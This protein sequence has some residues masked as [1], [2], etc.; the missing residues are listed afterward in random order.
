MLVHDRA[1]PLA[2]RR[3]PEGFFECA[4]ASAAPACTTTGPTNSA[5][6]RASRPT[7]RC[8]STAR[9][10]RSSIRPAWPRSRGKPVTDD[11]PPEMVDARNWKRYAIGHSGH[12]VVR[13]GDHLATD[14]L[15]TDAAAV[16]RA[17]RP[18]RNC[19][20]AISRTS[21]FGPGTTPDGRAL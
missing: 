5:R 13:D 19:P 16:A 17:P 18:A 8:G 9:P 14:L 3:T 10:T 11:H 21:I 1:T 15:I 7:T 2:R 4:P 20:T 6:R 12:E